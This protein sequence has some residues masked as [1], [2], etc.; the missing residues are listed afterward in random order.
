MRWL[1]ATASPWLRST[2]LDELHQA[3]G[4]PHGG[5]P[6]R[7]APFSQNNTCYSYTMRQH[8]Y[9]IYIPGLGDDRTYFQPT[10]LKTWRL[11]AVKVKYCAVGWRGNDFEQKL[12]KLSNLADRLNRQ[13][14][15]VSIVGISAGAS[16][17]VNLYTANQDKIS[18]V[19]LVCGKYRHPQ[20]VG[21]RYFSKN[22]NFRQS[23]ELSDKNFLRLKKTDLHKFMA[24]YAP[25]DKVV[26]AAEA[27]LPGGNNKSVLA[28]GHLSAI[29]LS[30]SIYQ[31]SII[32]FIHE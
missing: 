16:A 20:Y 5:R 27:K 17:A 26:P 11:S 21:D 12:N 1:V 32:K 19:V 9:V 29:F 15:E 4:R 2:G 14:H 13:G 23:L 3:L 28:L 22:P 31:R 7:R 10:I 24:L 18:K 6:T 25:P 8:H 30:I